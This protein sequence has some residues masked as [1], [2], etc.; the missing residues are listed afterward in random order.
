MNSDARELPEQESAAV[1]GLASQRRSSGMGHVIGEAMRGETVSTE[2]VLTALGG[3]R[4]MIE[5]VL[6]GLL[7]LVWFAFTQNAPQSL[8]APVAVAAVLLIIRLF[9]REKLMPAVTGILAVA[10]CAAATLI[11][12]NGRDYYA[13]GLFIN[14]G[15][16]LGLVVSL[17]VRWPLI[18]LIGGALLGKLVEWR[19]WPGFRRASFWLT[20]MWLGLFVA[21]LAVQLPLYLV[22]NV[23]ALGVARLAMGI[24]PYALLIIITWRVL[25]AAPKI[26]LTSSD[27]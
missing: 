16:I 6:P 14:A 21:R 5:S 24:P 26:P 9:R 18:G 3:V 10:V 15:W 17:V 8:I 1:S 23:E 22:G 11:T 12:G 20:I 2:G 19:A 25:A 13:P 4:G 7:F 27:D